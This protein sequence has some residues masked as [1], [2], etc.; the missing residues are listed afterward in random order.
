MAL[1]V[2]AD[3]FK[4]VLNLLGMARPMEAVRMMGA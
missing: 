2:L 3:N 1:H 4:R